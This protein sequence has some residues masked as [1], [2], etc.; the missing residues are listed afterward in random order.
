MRSLA[1]CVRSATGLNFTVTA[2]SAATGA[3][4]IASLP[5]RMAH[6]SPWCSLSDQ[7]VVMAVST[8][9]GSIVR[10]RFACSLSRS[11]SPSHH[12]DEAAGWADKALRRLPNYPPA[13]WALIVSNALAGRIEKAKQAWAMYQQ[14]EP[15][16]RISNVQ[17]R[18]GSV[19]QETLL[20]YAEALRIVGM[21]E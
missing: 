16:A 9:D 3:S 10:F 20:R 5:D 15:T 11:S 12:D 6:P 19:V 14:V 4:K 21:P 7:P 2:R 8:S 13:Y 17:A 18:M 1:A